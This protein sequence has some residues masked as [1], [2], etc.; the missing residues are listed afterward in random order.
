MRQKKKKNLPWHSML[1]LQYSGR[2]DDGYVTA[3]FTAAELPPDGKENVE[4]WKDNG[5]F[6]NT[7]SDSYIFIHS[8]NIY[9][10]MPI[11]FSSCLLYHFI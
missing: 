2:Q 5:N 10:F 9:A 6:V 7:S 8:F 3:F 1:L 11:S 4:G